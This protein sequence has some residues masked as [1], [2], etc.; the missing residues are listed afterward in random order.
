MESY[1]I[2]IVQ[3]NVAPYRVPLYEGLGKLYPN[4]VEVWATDGVGTPNVSQPLKGVRYDYSHPIKRIGPFRW[5]VGVSLKGMAP[6]D[7]LVVCGE[8][9]TLSNLWFAFWARVKGIAVVWWGHHQSATSTARRTRI[10]LWLAK[11]LADVFL[12]YTKT[13]IDFLVDRGFDPRRVF[14][15]WNTIDQAPIESAIRQWDSVALA[16]FRKHM[17]IEGHPVLLICSALREK[18]RLDLLLYA[19]A[20]VRLLERKTILV[21]IGEGPKEEACRQLAKDLKI[22]NSIRWIGATRDQMQMAPWF[23]SASMYIYPGAV[24]LGLIHALAYGLPAVVHGNA[25]RQ[26][27]EFEAMEDGKTGVLFRENDIDDLVQKILYLIDRPD[28]KSKMGAYSAR[29]VREQYSM[30]Q[31]IANYAHAIDAAHNFGR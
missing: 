27:P 4:R 18:T 21:I 16:E 17:A 25:E 7:V 19:M 23:L 10:R 30:E 29:K 9:Q 13:G 3:P 22:E 8:V 14:A 20:D 1:K 26:M 6:G 11:R 31:M 12:C 5:Q 2:R 24:G 15:T 28:E